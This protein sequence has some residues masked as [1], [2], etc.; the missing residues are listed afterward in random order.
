[1][2]VITRIVTAGAVVCCL[3]TRKSKISGTL[4][5]QIHGTLGPGALENPEHG[6]AALRIFQSSRP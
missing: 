5:K 6:F 3:L 4:G 1:M 2:N